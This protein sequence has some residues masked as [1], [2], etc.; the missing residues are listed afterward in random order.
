MSSP[1]WTAAFPALG[2]DGFASPARPD[3]EPKTK[4]LCMDR[5]T[6]FTRMSGSSIVV[7]RCED[8]GVTALPHLMAEYEIRSFVD[9][10][11]RI[12]FETWFAVLRKQGQAKV[13]F[14]LSRL[15][16]GDRSHV[17]GVG[18]GVAE[19]KLDWG[20]GYRI[21]FRNDGPTLLILLGGGM[22]KRRAEHIAAAKARWADYKARKAARGWS[23]R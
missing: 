19:L 8:R 4:K 17:K 5:M 6:N 18:D 7:S 13:T 10:N 15:E 21:Y 14:A 9:R 3:S 1:V 2:F 23:G 12:P 22:K 11:G 16:R 20:V